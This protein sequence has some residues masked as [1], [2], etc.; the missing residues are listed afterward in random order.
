MTTVDKSMSSFGFKL[1]SLAFRVRDFI[2]PRFK[3]LREAGIEAGFCILDFGCGPGGYTVP[4]AE[5]VG[6]SGKIYALD[7]HPLAIKEVKKR[8]AR[9]GIEIIETIESD[10]NTGLPDNIV[11]MVLL[12]DTFHKLSRPD[13]IL[14]ELNRVLKSGGTLS[15]S[16]H[17]MKEQDI[18]KRV[19]DKGMF[20][21]S[22][23]GRKTYRFTKTG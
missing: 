7:K 14:Q 5:L 3:L 10:C 19:T 11:D 6:T 18:L 15:F 22:Q 8:A 20:K 17:H 4:L 16:D 23:K 13:D 21:F 2:R 9:K 12:Y 1:M